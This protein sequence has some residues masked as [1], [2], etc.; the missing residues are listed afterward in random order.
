MFYSPMIK[1]DL[2][3]F[4]EPM[5][6]TLKYTSI[7]QCP[8]SPLLGRTGY[9]HRA[10]FKYVPSPIWKDEIISGYFP[11]PSQLRSDNTPSS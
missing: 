1:S 8:P 5:L 6:W 4:S 11:S 2:K 7:S 3:N 10:E 9:L